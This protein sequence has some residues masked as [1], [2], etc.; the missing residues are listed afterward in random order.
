MEQ[1][2]EKR[3]VPPAPDPNSAKYKLNS[4]V[5]K[6]Y[7]EVQEAKQAGEKIG[8]CASNFPQEIFQT[9]GVKVCYPEN[10]A[11]A[12]AA[13]GG[14]QR[15]CEQ[16]ESKG[17]SNDICAY[18]RINLAYLD[19]K[20]IPEQNMPQPDFLL[21]C[22]NICNCMI[23]WYEN[24]AKECNIPLILIDI[25][26]N[27]DYEVS[28]EKVAY[29]AAQFRAAIAQLEKI[30]GKKWDEKR[31]EE[32]C[33]ISNR[34]SKAWL[35]ATA[36]TKY[37]PSPL[38]GFDLLNH[39][40]VAVCA[41]GTVEAAEAFETLLE[42]YKQAVKD[43]TS[44]FKGEQKYRIMFEGIACW[45][46]LKT[47]A[48]GLRDRGINMVATIY[49]D[50]FGLLYNDFEGMIK[51]YCNVPNSVSLEK[52]RDNRIDIVKRTNAEGML[53]HT[54]RS[55]KL[56]SGFMAEMSRQIGKSCDIPVVSFD[57]DQADPRNFSDAQYHTRVEGLVEIMDSHKSSN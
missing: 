31:F 47:T 27:A 29:V 50:A 16:A 30:T 26:F 39:M 2:K 36:Y 28:D 8:W 32:V 35:E 18:A 5:M 45:P 48:L 10:Q 33:K 24:I 12:I 21:C 55:C 25:P 51:C 22:N 54:N 46:H 14:G 11:A 42:E 4:V 9:L 38:N 6:H 13:R 56:W 52:G 34:T 23:K 20:E 37:T 7:R 44:T 43:G 40:A 1:A 3:P 49:A 15:M 19:A 57:G 41:R 17:Y 53:V